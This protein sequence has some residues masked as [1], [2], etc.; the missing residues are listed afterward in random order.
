MQNDTQL[1]IPYAKSDIFLILMLIV[2]TQIVIILG[3]VMLSVAVSPQGNRLARKKIYLTQKML[4]GVGLL[5][6]TP[7]LAPTGS[8]AAMTDVYRKLRHLV[9]ISPTFYEQLLRQNPFAKKLQAQIVST[10]K[11]RKKTFIRKSCS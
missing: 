7:K 11:L 5:S 1:R 4:E 2:V 8:D 10:Q 6:V 3:V 9:S